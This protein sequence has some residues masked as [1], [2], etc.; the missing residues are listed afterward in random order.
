MNNDIMSAQRKTASIEVAHLV[1]SI[2]LVS[3]SGIIETF[4]VSLILRRITNATF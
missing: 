3:A 1:C 4:C 2:G